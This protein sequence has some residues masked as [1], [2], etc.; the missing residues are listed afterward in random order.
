MWHNVMLACC[1]SMYR[2]D[3]YWG[4]VSIN[5]FERYGKIR[6]SKKLAMQ[7][8]EKLAVELLV[9]IRDGVKE[10]MKKHGIEDDES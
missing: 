7:D 4:C 2:Q 10:L 9:D 8:A 1:S 6:R 3:E 5:G